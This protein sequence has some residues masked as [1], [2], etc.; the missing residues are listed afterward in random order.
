MS[1][2]NYEYEY[3]YKIVLMGDSKV[4]KSSVFNKL[5]NI[6]SYTTTTTIGVDFCSLIKNIRGKNIKICLWDTAGQEK[7]KVMIRSYF[8]EIAGVI[9][10]FDL[11][12]NLSFENT[13]N[14]IKLLDLENKCD[15]DHPILLLGN[16]SDKTP[17]DVPSSDIEKL[18][19][20]K[21]MVY[22]EI[23]CKNDNIITLEK[24]FVS[25]LER[26]NDNSNENCKGIQNYN[27]DSIDILKSTNQTK[28]CCMY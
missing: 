9:L 10:V 28:K 17:I 19:K 14:W 24:I 27:R 7:F 18:C 22:K 1:Y 12:D 16:K 25:F 20:G 26:I 6:V 8:R 2:C 4:G 23:S 11:T 5:N 3:R 21:N 15:H 13:K